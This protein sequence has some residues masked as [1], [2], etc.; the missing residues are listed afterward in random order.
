MA[1]GRRTT[2]PKHGRAGRDWIEPHPPASACCAPNGRAARGR[3][4]LTVGTL[5]TLGF[6]FCPVQVSWRGA[7]VDG[8]ARHHKSMRLHC[9]RFLPAELHGYGLFAT[10]CRRSNGNNT[11]HLRQG[12]F[13]PA[14]RSC[15]ALAPAQFPCGLAGWVAQAQQVRQSAVS[16]SHDS[17]I[18]NCG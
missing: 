18:G 8:A 7:Q 5:L 12:T 10:A 9:S 16:Q 4:G 17:C 11:R 15:P 1:D 13:A 14:R 3:R 6:T 2:K